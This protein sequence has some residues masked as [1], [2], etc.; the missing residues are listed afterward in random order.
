MVRCYFY[1]YIIGCYFL[2]IFRELFSNLVRSLI[3]HQSHGYFSKCFGWN[4]GFGSFAGVT[5]PDSVAVECRANGGSFQSGKSFFPFNSF[6]IDGF[7]KFFLII[8][9]FGHF[10]SFFGRKFQ[11]II[12][13]TIDG[14]ASVFINQLCNHSGK[15]MNWIR[16]SA[17]VQSGMQISSRAFH[18]Y[19]HITEAAQTGSYGWLI[20]GIQTG[21]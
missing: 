9:Q 19:F 6:Q 5:T 7:F 13:K 4:H 8:F 14:N 2:E 21:I 1:F 10:C 11:N 3:R 20:L 15:H 12:V 18:F 16:N 17:T